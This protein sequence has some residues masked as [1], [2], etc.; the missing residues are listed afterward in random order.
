MVVSSPYPL[1]PLITYFL[2]I[3][4]LDTC[5]ELAQNKRKEKLI[6]RLETLLENLLLDGLDTNFSVEEMEEYRL[7]LFLIYLDTKAWCVNF[8]SVQTDLE[9]LKI[10]VEDNEWIRNS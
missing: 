1:L 5:I 4:R 8:E 10:V 9:Y 3:R 2:L 7:R 6:F